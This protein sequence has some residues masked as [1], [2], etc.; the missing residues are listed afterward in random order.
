MAGIRDYPINH[1]PL[2]YGD[3]GFDSTGV[4]V[5]A[6][7]E[8]WNGTQWDVRKAL[9]NKWDD[10]FPYQNEKL[11]KRC[12]EGTANSSPLPADRCPGNRRWIQLMFDGFLLQ[13]GATS[14]LD[15]RDSML[16]ADQMRFDGENQKVLWR[17]FAQNGMGKN[18]STKGGDDGQP[19]PGFVAPGHRLGDRDVR[20]AGRRREG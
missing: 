15:A 8:I 2:T 17:A 4:E 20:T 1:N 5:H 16:A 19:K 12:A 6:D 11:Q 10:E 18:A 7:G 14:M 3:Y 13:Q 9:V